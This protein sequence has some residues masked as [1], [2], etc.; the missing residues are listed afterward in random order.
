MIKNLL[1]LA[2][3]SMFVNVKNFVHFNKKIYLRII[4]VVLIILTP[5]IF[6]KYDYIYMRI[7]IRIKLIHQKLLLFKNFNK[8]SYLDFL[9]LNN[10]L[11]N[12]T[13]MN[14]NIGNYKQYENFI[15]KYGFNYNKKEKIRN[16]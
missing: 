14:H 7:A 16:W 15:D 13:L 1:L 3:N 6:I 5:A 10:P 9:K 11:R 4:L 12:P 8:I 2:K